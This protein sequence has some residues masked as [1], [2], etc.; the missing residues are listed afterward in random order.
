MDLQAD[1]A[2]GVVDRRIGL[3][4][5]QRLLAIKTDDDERT[6]GLDL[7][8]IPFS[9][10]LEGGDFRLFLDAD[11]T[12]AGARAGEELLATGFVV[13]RAGMAMADIGLIADHL[14]GRIGRALAAELHAGVNEAFG[15]GQLILERQAE[16][17][18]GALGRQ[19]LVTRITLHGS[20]HDLA[21][22]DSPDLGISVPTRE[23]LAVEQ[24]RR[25]GKESE[26]SGE[27]AKG[28]DKTLH[29]VRS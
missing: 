19:E 13:E 29:G 14:V 22:L 21:V 5:G 8:L 3:A 15:S 25:R 11:A 6:H 10:L 2:I 24:G 1:E 7:V 27:Q 17:V 18:K 26:D 9:L 12:V 16:V 20:A 28:G 23:R 4:V